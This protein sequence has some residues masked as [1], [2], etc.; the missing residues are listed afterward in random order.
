M[1]KSHFFVA[2]FLGTG[3]KPNVPQGWHLEIRFMPSHVP[4]KIPHS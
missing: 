2:F 3:S 1:D 4:L